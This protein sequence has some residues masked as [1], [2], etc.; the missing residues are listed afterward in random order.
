MFI[1]L[2]IKY[3]CFCYTVVFS[4]Y[5]RMYGPRVENI[6]HVVLCRKTFPVPDSKGYQP[7]IIGLLKVLSDQYQNRTQN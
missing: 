6:Y 7:Y 2:Y 5:D 1:Y 4:S 3:D